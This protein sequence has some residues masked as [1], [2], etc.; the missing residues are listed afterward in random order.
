[1]RAVRLGTFDIAVERR[2]DGA[3]LVRPTNA[4]GPYP[5]TITAWLD[6]WAAKAPNRAFLV[7]RDATG[8]WRAMTY[9][10]VL[11]EVRRI[12][13]ALL[14]RDL[15][16]ERPVAILSG[17]D[18]DHALLALAAMYVGIPYAPISPAY[19][20]LS[21]DFGKLRTIM[22]LVTPG[23]VFANDGTP[24]A[25]AIEAVVP[26]DVEVMVS[27]NKPGNRP[28]TLFADAQA[29]ASVDTAH[30]VTGLDTIAKFLFTSGS[31]GIPKA[32]INTHRMLCSNQAMLTAAYR[33]LED[34]PPVIVD[35]LPWNHTYGG[36][37]NFNMVLMHGGT[38]HIDDGNPTPPGVP[39]TVRNLREVAPT[40]YY[41][42]PK[43]YE[44]LVPYLRA[45]KVLRD[46]FFSRVKVLCYAGASLNQPTWDALRELSPRRSRSP[47]PTTSRGRAISAFP[48]P[49]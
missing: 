46:T 49:A 27:R 41:N 26:L 38:I 12:G 39:K 37:H 22:R 19:S 43:G 28:A 15:S 24:F 18:I 7:E 44:A 8:A 29:D 13:A 33:F 3:L 35:W 10:D 48:P 20:L 11:C 25:R 31:T 23:L 1:M 34:E 9:A 47:A 42:V 4:L 2:T 14:R 32:V 40:I 30:A 17:N 21:S 5:K 6:H 45:D 16:P 36:N